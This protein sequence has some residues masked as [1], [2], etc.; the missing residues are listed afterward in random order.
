MVPSKKEMPVK[1]REN[2]ESFRLS[3]GWRC[4][5]CTYKVGHVVPRVWRDIPDNESYSIQTHTND[6]NTL[7]CMWDNE[8][9]DEKML[10]PPTE[11]KSPHKF[12]DNVDY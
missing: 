8:K 6:I 3:V 12:L 9:E 7:D 11:R 1:W 4:A 10:L 5:I 2:Q